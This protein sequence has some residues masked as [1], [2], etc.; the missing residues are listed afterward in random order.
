[1]DDAIFC[2]RFSSISALSERWGG[3]NE[4]QYAMELLLRLEAGENNHTEKKKTSFRK[5]L[6]TGPD[7][8]I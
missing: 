7:S 5:K 4:R 1:M 6:Q 3:E 8:S 2:V